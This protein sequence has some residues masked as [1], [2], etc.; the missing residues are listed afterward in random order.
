MDH[1]FGLT[2]LAV[3]DALAY[4]D[5]FAV[6]VTEIF[7]PASDLVSLYLLLVA[8]LMAFPSRSHW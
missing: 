6:T 1:R 4:A 5:R 2:A 3:F 7:F 8:P